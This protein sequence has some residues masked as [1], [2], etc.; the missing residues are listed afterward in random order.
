MTTRPKLFNRNPKVVRAVLLT[1]GGIAGAA[2][3]HA[4][5]WSFN[6]LLSV[7]G[8]Y[9]DNYLMDSDTQGPISVSGADIEG[10]VD[11]RRAT[12][13]GYVSLVP[14]VHASFYDESEENSTDGYLSGVLQHQGQK[15]RAGTTINYA[16]E[17]TSRS[18]RPGIDDPDLGEPDGGDSGLIITNNKRELISLLPSL[19]FD[20]TQRNSLEVR[21]RFSDVSFDKTR[22]GQTGYTAYGGSL[23]WV[24]KLSQTSTLTV[25][26]DAGKYDPDTAFSRAADTYGAEAEWGRQFSDIGQTYFRGGF[27]RT[28]QDALPTEVE[29]PDT[30]TSYVGGAGV[31]W[32]FPVNKVLFD[33]TLSVDPN[34]SGVLVKRDQVRFRL[35]H[36]FSQRW[37]GDIGV[38]YIRDKSV[39]GDVALA[40][41]RYGVATAGLAWRQ[42]RTISYSGEYNY[43][44]QKYDTPQDRD[45]MSNSVNLSVVYEPHRQD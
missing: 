17:T 40:E 14:R 42:T 27:R 29:K 34:A 8:T 31:Q 32:T 2:A 15:F 22:S 38:R 44:N 35:D 36:Q 24:Y 3:A 20:M 6:P 11:L 5:D 45:A 41:R 21:T 37:V 7:G 33:L 1:L 10:Q 16:N 28:K 4:S 26:G 19:Q 30:T 9:D 13:T 18:E 12:P 43:R 39:G 23:G 25:R